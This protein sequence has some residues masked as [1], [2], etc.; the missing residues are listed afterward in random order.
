AKELTPDLGLNAY[1]FE[2]RTLTPAFPMFSQQDTHAEKYYPLSPYLYCAGNPINLVDPT[3]EEPVYNTKGEF[4]GN[5]SEGF[6]GDVLIY[7]GKGTINFSKYNRTQLEAKYKS[8]IVKYDEV[9][10]AGSRVMSSKSHSKIWT[11]IVSQFEGQMIY[12]E[13]FSMSRLPG[14]KVGYNRRKKGSWYTTMTWDK[15][16]N[17]P[18]IFGTG[19]Y[20]YESTVENIASSIIVHEWYSHWLKH[21]RD[22]MKSHRLAY[23]NVINF[24]RLWNNTTE[25]YKKFNL[26]KL[27]EYTQ[28]ET[29]RSTVDYLYQ[30][31]YRKYVK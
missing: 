31:L 24:K 2:A 22:D 25:E 13:K 18:V 10:V 12:D 14:A 17:G 26:I 23:K 28:R 29:G 3:G 11:H 7:M 1:D 19:K 20:K 9:R 27:Q 4:L 21:N 5:T 15:P 8:E 6:T 16:S 30:R